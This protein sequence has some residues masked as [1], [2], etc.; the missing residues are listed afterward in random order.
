M[1]E[2]DDFLVPTLARQLEADQALVNGTR[3]RAWR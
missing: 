2:L 1:S 3:D